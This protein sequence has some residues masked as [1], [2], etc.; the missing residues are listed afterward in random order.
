MQSESQQDPC[1]QC[2]SKI[3]VGYYMNKHFKPECLGCGIP[4]HSPIA[5]NAPINLRTLVNDGQLA[6]MEVMFTVL[7]ASLVPGVGEKLGNVAGEWSLGKESANADILLTLQCLDKVKPSKRSVGVHDL[8]RKEISTDSLIALLSPL[9]PLR[10][11]EAMYLP[12]NAKHVTAKQVVLAGLNSHPVF[13]PVYVQANPVGG[14]VAGCAD[15]WLMLAFMCVRESLGQCANW[16]PQDLTETNLFGNLLIMIG[17]AL[18]WIKLHVDR[19]EAL[20]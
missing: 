19:T 4:R 6:A 10:L 5:G 2:K 15:H 9:D 18:T 12:K 11:L 16:W 20:N 14:A 13:P 7:Q 3:V 8:C 1:I 17:V